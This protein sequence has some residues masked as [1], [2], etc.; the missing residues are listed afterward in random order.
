MLVRE[1]PV[2][3]GEVVRRVLAT[4]IDGEP[5]LHPVSGIGLARWPDIAPTAEWRSGFF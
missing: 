3:G 1:I 4:D 5:G 2:P